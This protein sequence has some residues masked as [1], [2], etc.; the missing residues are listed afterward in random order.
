VLNSDPT[1]HNVNSITQNN[2]RSNDTQTVG[3]PPL[4]VVFNRPEIAIMLKCNLHPWMRA[5]VAVMSNPYFQVTG[6]DGSFDLT[7]VPPGTYKVTAWH[8]RYGVSEQ[9]VTLSPKGEAK[10]SIAFKSDGG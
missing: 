4:E 8:E 10:V 9:I 6:K 2:R 3:G 7:N 5:H 1:T